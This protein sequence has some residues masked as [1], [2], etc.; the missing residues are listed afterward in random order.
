M[1]NF[2][3]TL[4][5]T[6]SGEIVGIASATFSGSFGVSLSA[7]VDGVGNGSGSETV[8][9]NIQVRYSYAD[10]R[11]G[12]VTVP[13]NLPTTNV[14]LKSGAF[15]VNEPGPNLFPG[16]QFGVSLNGAISADQHQITENVYA[17][18]T[19][20]YQGIGVSET[21]TATGT[22]TAAP[23]PVSP[24]SISGSGGSQAISDTSA[25]APFRNA[26]IAD[27]NPGATDTVR[28]TVSN[29][30]NGTLSNLGG[31]SFN[32]STG[33]FTVSGSAAVVSAAVDGLV[34][35]PTAHQ[36][37][38][39][40]TVTTSFTISV[41]DTMGQSANGGTAS[42]TTTETL[43]G[44]L[45]TSQQLELIYIA[46]FNRA[47]DG[48]GFSFWNGQNVSAQNGGQ[49]AARA[50]TNIANSFAPQ[51]ETV[52]IYSFLGPLV[53]GGTVNLNTPAAQAGLTAFVRA[54]YQNL[55]NRVADPTGQSYWVGQI[56][57]GA[58]GLGA[59]ALAIA[60]GA[61][62]F[63]A[64]EVQNKIAV[65]L[66]FTTR[67]GAAGLGATG[68]LP[69][70]F[71]AAARGVLSG[72]DGTSL[73]DGSVTAGMSATTAYISATAPPTITGTIAGQMVTDQ[74]TIT[75]FSKVTIAD[76]VPADTITLT[77]SAAANG[78]FSNLGGSSY[79]AT[80]GIYTDT[81]TAAALTSAVDGLVFTPTAHQV[82]VGQTVVTTFTIADTD[83]VGATATDNTTSVIGTAADYTIFVA[84][85]IVNPAPGNHTIQ[86]L[87]GQ[88]GTLV[89]HLNGIDQISGFDPSTEV[90]DLSF[91]L[92]EANVN[93]NGSVAALGNYL[94][95]T[96]QGANALLSFD[97][98]GHGGGSTVAVLLGLG[99]TVTGLNTLVADGAIRIA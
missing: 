22:L 85:D 39:G 27:P 10:G 18:A 84:S 57:T 88:T 69:N 31:G 43:L 96:E 24:V 9:G 44:G 59:A 37:A 62:G 29:V 47:A 11:T 34:F 61:T 16:L 67:T 28:I 13:F 70:G 5:I 20:T 15:Q 68:P 83:S 77:L 45:S 86:F 79:N 3:G 51:P 99:S 35:T 23:P 8:K 2:A 41:S 64:T 94:A 78:R 1:T 38:T 93:L 50:L 40:Q 81:G 56:T 65:A 97:P 91:L 98:T 60:N 66:D 54:V 30:A 71:L 75:P 49:S 82:A 58:V 74:T 25:V 95:V 36:A 87:P 14:Q 76:T 4:N 73:N 90:L 80:T 92:S 52:A 32:P 33:G 42:V 72:V 6:G 53:S 63:D 48:A 21:V 26:V 46:Y 17:V 12:N 19:G 55:F 7:T 89:L